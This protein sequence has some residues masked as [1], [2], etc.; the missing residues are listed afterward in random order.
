MYI[1]L[2][3]SY[4]TAFDVQVKV[5]EILKYILPF[6]RDKNDQ[7]WGTNYQIFKKH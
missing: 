2:N 1:K 7:G 3:Y 6:S 5:T 4:F